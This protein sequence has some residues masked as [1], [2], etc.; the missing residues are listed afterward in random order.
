MPLP[1][2]TCGPDIVLSYSTGAQTVS[3]SATATN[4]PTSFQWTILSVP[5][6]STALTETRGNFV[7]GVANVQ[8]PTFETDGGISGTYVMQCVA[9][10]SEGSSVPAVD[11]ENGQQPVI[12]KTEKEI[13]LPNDFQ[14]DWSAYN[15]NNFLILEAVSPTSD[16]KNALT[17]TS[18]TPSISNKYVTDSDPRMTDARTPTSHSSTHENGGTDEINVSGLSGILADPQNAGQLQG[19]NISSSSPTVSGQIL[20][21][22]GPLSQW[23]AQSPAPAVSNFLSL[24]DVDPNNYTGQTGKRVA[25]NSSETGL[26]FVD[27]ELKETGG[28]TILTMGAVA[29]GQF[30]QRSGNTIVGVENLTPGAD[31]HEIKEN[32]VPNTILDLTGSFLGILPR[33]GSLSFVTRAAR[34]RVTFSAT[35]FW[36]AVDSIIVK[37]VFDEGTPAEQTIGDDDYWQQRGTSSGD[38]D[39]VHFTDSVVLTAGIHTV[40]VYAREAGSGPIKI[41]ATVPVAQPKLT[42]TELSSSG[43]GGTLEQEFIL[44]QD[45][46]TSSSSYVNV[47]DS[48]ANPMRVTVTTMEGERVLILLG[49]QSTNTTDPSLV[50][51]GIS[52]DGAAPTGALAEL[53]YKPGSVTSGT[54]ASMV[55]TSVLTPP[56]S[57]GSHTLTVQ[58][59]RVDGSG[60]V[61]LAGSA[62]AGSRK[63]WIQTMQFRGGYTPGQR[64]WKY[65]PITNPDTV[66]NS[67]VA[68]WHF[69][70]SASDLI[71]R[72]GNGHTLTLSGTDY[73][74][75]VNDLIGRQFDGSTTKLTRADPAL[76]LLGALTIEI[77]AMINKDSGDATFIDHGG[78]ASLET[79][80]ENVLYRITALNGSNQVQYFNEQGSGTDETINMKGGIPVGKLMY[81]AITRSASGV[82]TLY[83]DGVKI[84]SGSVTLPTDG[85]GGSLQIGA[86][87]DVSSIQYLSGVICSV[88]ITDEEFTA[89]EV[90]AAFRSIT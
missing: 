49:L 71:D 26:E 81:I 19:N 11:K 73:H 47:T 67:P 66:T 87:S 23:E 89:T 9:T 74:T 4:S 78:D 29:S 57:A 45:F 43:A 62:V 33:S 21:W 40:T 30:L 34:Y 44:D 77:I 53:Q 15:N 17:G 27:P 63:S 51:Y 58:M 88:R 18:G 14:Y 70:K 69:D 82:V 25:V 6:G 28:P 56:L 20:T 65:F 50:R 32:P 37:A 60:T 13:T 86:A 75:V 46:S 24:T 80:V 12:V 3:L 72:T 36:D 68:V 5:P 7:N 10:N 2:V 35:A 79:S 39:Q 83:L 1:K 42:L 64:V 8:N 84:D 54:P 85:S 61:T 16:E 48:G 38:Y 22:N 90:L 59:K 31:Y 52:I 76:R 41:I 55:G